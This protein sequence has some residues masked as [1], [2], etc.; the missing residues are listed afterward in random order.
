MAV[1]TLGFPSRFG[2]W[3]RGCAAP[4]VTLLQRTEGP[5]C[6]FVIDCPSSG[7]SG[8]DSI[9]G[10]RQWTPQLRRMPGRYGFPGPAFLPPAEEAQ[11]RG[12]IARPPVV[13]QFQI[14]PLPG[15]QRIS[16]PDRRAVSAGAGE[17]VEYF[18]LAVS[19]RTGQ[20]GSLLKAALTG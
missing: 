9:E 5:S 11:A 16:R 15:R 7:Q 1:S 6:P 17:Q 13:G 3:P 18:P 14:D 2:L 19:F 10:L 8:D 20:V 12:L 4:S